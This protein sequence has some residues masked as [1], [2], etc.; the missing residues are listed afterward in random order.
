MQ[1]DARFQDVVAVRLARSKIAIGELVERPCV[2]LSHRPGR[3]RSIW[4]RLQ[5]Y[6]ASGRGTHFVL[7]RILADIVGAG[8]AQRELNAVLRRIRNGNRIGGQRQARAVTAVARRSDIE[9]EDTVPARVGSRR[10]VG[11]I[12]DRIGKLL[13]K[14]ARLDFGGQLAGDELILNLGAL[15][16]GPGIEPQ[17]CRRGHQHH[18]ETE[19]ENRRSHPAARDAGSSHGGDLTVAGHAAESDECGD[20]N[21]QRNRIRE[22]LREH[23]SEQVGHQ[24]GRPGIAHQKFEQ[25]PR[26]LQKQDQSEQGAAQRRAGQYFAEQS[27]A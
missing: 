4:F 2:H 17:R 24:P 15:A 19:K 14:N 10:N 6:V 16:D 22:R 23:Q 12:D 27:A 26:A 13:L 1:F 3:Q 18:Q 8:I 5:R 7:G 21:S 9:Q 11:D 25:R 20:Q